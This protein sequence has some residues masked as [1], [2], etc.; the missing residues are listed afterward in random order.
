VPDVTPLNTF[1][2]YRRFHDWLNNSRDAAAQFCGWEE[3]HVRLNLFWWVTGDWFGRHCRHLMAGESCSTC[4]MAEENQK[5]NDELTVLCRN[6]ASRKETGKWS[7]FLQSGVLKLL[8]LLRIT[9]RLMIFAF[10]GL[11]RC[12]SLMM[13]WRV[14]LDVRLTWQR[15]VF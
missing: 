11:H 12:L 14:T 4:N 3:Q 6:D 2:D 8:P 15:S 7:L 9:F 1:T 5:S 13:D 10:L